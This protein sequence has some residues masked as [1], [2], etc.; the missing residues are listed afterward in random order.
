MS[1]ASQSPHAGSRLL[2]RR[3]GGKIEA[4]GQ[5]GRT[6]GIGGESGCNF[7]EPA[8]VFSISLGTSVLAIGAEPHDTP[9]ALESRRSAAWRLAGQLPTSC[10]SPIRQSAGKALPR[11]SWT[12]IQRRLTS[13]RQFAGSSTRLRRTTSRAGRS[14]IDGRHAGSTAS[15]TISIRNGCTSCRRIMPRSSHSSA[16][17]RFGATRRL[18]V[19]GSSAAPVR[20]ARARGLFLCRPLFVRRARFFR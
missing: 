1:P 3:P 15:S 8:T 11:R 2:L 13:P 7:N 10:R 5:S 12:P 9:A 20:Q 4:K 17:R 18:A 6:C 16:D 19:P 14:T